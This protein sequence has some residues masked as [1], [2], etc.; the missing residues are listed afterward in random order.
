MLREKRSKFSIVSS[1]DDENITSTRKSIIRNQTNLIS[2][3]SADKAN[4]SQTEDTL[5]R[6]LDPLTIQNVIVIWLNLNAQHPHSN[7]DDIIDKFREVAG[8]FHVFTDLNEC[9]DFI[10]DIANEHVILIMSN[11]HLQPLVSIFE[12]ISQL[13]SIF[14]LDSELTLNDQQVKVCKK[15][16]GIFTNFNVII[17]TLRQ[18]LIRQQFD[19]APFSIV[20]ITSTSS[21]DQLDQSFMYTQLIKEIILDI[22]H[23][24][25]ARQAFTQFYLKHPNQNDFRSQPL[26][27]FEKY[28]DRHSPIWWYTKE[29]FVYST[30]NKALRIQD[31]E[32][33]I[34]MGFF[35][36][37]L[38]DEIKQRHEEVSHTTKMI[39]YRGQGLKAT[40]VEKIR[41]NKG[42]LFAFNSFLSTSMDRK[43]SLMFAESAR[44]N[45][46]M[47][48]VLFRMEIDSSISSAPYVSLCDLSKFG[49]EEE[50]LFSMHT[51]FRIGELTKIQDSLWEISLALTSDNDPDL[52]SLTD[53]LREEIGFIGGWHRMGMLMMKIGKYESALEIF[54]MLIQTRFDDDCDID[55]LFRTFVNINIGETHRSIGEYSS[56]L[57]HLKK[58]LETYQN[59]FP[60]DNPIFGTIYNNTAVV[61]LHMGDYTTALFNFEQAFN[62][63]RKSLPFDHPFLAT[64]YNNTALVYQFM[65]NFKMALSF[66]EETLKILH[67]SLPTNH[68]TLATI[69]HNIASIHY[70]TGNYE[71]ALSY[72]KKTFEIFH[73]SLP[74]DHPDFAMLYINMADAHRSCGY[75]ETAL[76]YSKKALAILQKSLP[77]NHSHMACCYISIGDSHQSLGNYRKALSYFEKGLAIMQT[78]L[79]HDHPIVSNFHARIGIVNQL[80]NNHKNALN[81][82]ENAAKLQQNFISK[83]QQ[84]L[85]LSSCDPHTMQE[86]SNYSAEGISHIKNVIE[87]L[88]KLTSSS[89]TQSDALLANPN[90][91]RA[92]MKSLSVGLSNFETLFQKIQQS[93]PLT[94]SK[95][96][97]SNIDATDQ[98]LITENMLKA[99]S[100]MKKGCET[101]Q[102]LFLLD[103]TATISSDDDDDD[104]N[105]IQTLLND[106]LLGFSHYTQGMEIQQKY[107]P[108]NDPSLG[109]TY[110]SFGKILCDMKVYQEGLLYFEKAVQVM[111]KSLSNNHPLLAKTYSNMAMALTGLERYEEAANCAFRAVEIAHSSGEIDQMEISDYESQLDQL[112]QMTESS[113]DV[114]SA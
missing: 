12:D 14:I 54:N 19:Q 24:H 9:I 32:M 22:E 72:F 82:L 50:I 61:H 79:S 7:I 98:D 69:Y 105:P 77:H 106:F 44:Q 5:H 65:R 110:N 113:N 43:V 47:H 74:S 101:M 35:L 21:L 114:D 73:K 23:D 88:Q 93:S 86:C 40:D 13:K 2:D 49:D 45:I 83:N 48:G 26:H 95:C 3:L 58:A 11:H 17:E 62:I 39:V 36:R 76:S 102:N 20:S 1:S 85:Q 104:E 92:F 6:T 84:L 31:T 4:K 46:D 56:A 107:L 10:T 64:C 70:S 90:D 52:K 108:P 111:S 37:D 100:Y 34:K 51:V 25:N 87:S 68:P 8:S 60:H 78:S 89:R 109:A 63:Y 66:F 42:G 96:Y 18:T 81:S 59:I 15:V 112:L 97:E 41:N 99:I 33:M 16:Q 55:E 29:P 94:R 80:M 28:Y 30:L 53:Y 27:Q 91:I 71:A 75:R 57:K 67:K 38:H 103:N